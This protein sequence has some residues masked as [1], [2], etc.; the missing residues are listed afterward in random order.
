MKGFFFLYPQIRTHTRK[1]YRDLDPQSKQNREGGTRDRAGELGFETDMYHHAG[2]S[3]LK[4]HARMFTLQD[5][6]K[7]LLLILHF[8][9]KREI[10]LFSLSRV[11]PRAHDVIGTKG[12]QREEK[13]NLKFEFEGL[14]NTC[15]DFAKSGHLQFSCTDSPQLPPVHL[16]TI[17]SFS[18][19]GKKVA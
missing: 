7:H 4:Q 6:S 1:F 15:Q 9:C 16:A 19:T 14:Q 10:G 8:S 18:S 5:F 2:T 11:N 12:L 3:P 13:E 17:P